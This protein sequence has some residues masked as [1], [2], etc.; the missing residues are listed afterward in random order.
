MYKV[1]KTH[2]GDLF[3]SNLIKLKYKSTLTTQ[4]IA[5]G[6]GIARETISCWLAGKRFPSARH[7]DA[8]AKYFGVKIDYLFKEN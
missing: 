5:D 4:E 8:I 2:A 3:R 7:I 1:I 6:T